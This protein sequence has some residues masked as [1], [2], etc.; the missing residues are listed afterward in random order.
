MTAPPEHAPRDTAHP[1][2]RAPRDSA[3]PETPRTQRH[4]AQVVLLNTP[5]RKWFYLTHSPNTA[6]NCFPLYARTSDEPPKGA[7]R[8]TRLGA[9]IDF[10]SSIFTG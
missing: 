8:G 1:E 6:A 3:H 2:T 7:S 10:F 9:E 4:R 5:P